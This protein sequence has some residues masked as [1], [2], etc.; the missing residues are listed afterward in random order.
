MNAQLQEALNAIKPELAARYAKLYRSSFSAM[1]EA[2]GPSLQGVNG[3]YQ[4]SRQYNEISDLIEC[5]PSLRLFISEQMKAPKFLNDQ[6]VEAKAAQ[7]AEL[8][9]AQWI[10]KIDA[11]MGDLSHVSVAR[12]GGCEFVIFGSR[13]DRAVKIEQSVIVKSSNKGLLFNQFPSRIYVDGKFTSEAAYKKM[14]A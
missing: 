9:V 3:S 6:K 2:L 12:F 7:M 14:F 5:D 13:A 11:K 1:V 4:F 8:A 10:N